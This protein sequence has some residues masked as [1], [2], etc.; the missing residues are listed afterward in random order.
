MRTQDL[1]FYF[2]SGFHLISGF[3][4]KIRAGGMKKE[5]QQIVVR[6]ICWINMYV[7]TTIQANSN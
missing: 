5:G 1:T 6:Y 7:L 3:K 2:F 4:A